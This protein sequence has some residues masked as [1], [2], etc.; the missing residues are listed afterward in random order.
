M[1]KLATFD[2]GETASGR[3]GGA[4]S[5]GAR[6]IGARLGAVAVTLGLLGGCAWL[7]D[8][9]DTNRYAYGPGN[10]FQ[11]ASTADGEEDIAS[12]FADV[13]NVR[14]EGLMWDGDP[15]EPFNRF[16][17][18]INDTLDIFI[19]KP[20]AVTYRRWVPDGVRNVVDNF[21]THLNEPVDFANSVLQGDFEQ[22]E[23]TASRFLINSAIGFGMFDPATG[24]GLEQRDEDFGQTLAVWGA[25]SGPYLVL[26]LIGPATARSAIGRGVD[27]FLDPVSYLTGNPVVEWTTGV[28]GVEPLNDYGAALFVADAVNF[29]SQNIDTLDAVRAD[30]IDYYARIRSLWTQ[31]RIRQILNETGGD[32]GAEIGQAP[33]ATD[34]VSTT[35]R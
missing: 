20:I 19:L 4:R 29:R 24:L 14:G 18:A 35:V 9:E 6:S 30:A 33:A 25:P 10:G 2:T 12:D 8:L 22:A 31:Q 15:L 7:P 34:Q 28:E 5:G 3:S 16:M 23:T 32:G 17:F 11:L 13:A 21:L 1:G 27:L 26:P